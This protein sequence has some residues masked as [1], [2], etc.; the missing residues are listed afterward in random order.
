[1]KLYDYNINDLLLR[2][3]RNP[4]ISRKEIIDFVLK[5]DLVSQ[6]KVVEFL[7]EYEEKY[8]VDWDAE[9]K[10]EPIDPYKEDIVPLD[11]DDN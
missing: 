8:P 5:S 4:Q 6:E 7:T 11:W 9:L 10:G 1:M 2:M 3:L